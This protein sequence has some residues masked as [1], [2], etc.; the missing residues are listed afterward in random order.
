MKRL[1]VVLTCAMAC[2]D[3]TV[4]DSGGRSLGVP[5]PSS[6]VAATPKGPEKDIFV[7]PKRTKRNAS[8][9]DVRSNARGTFL[10][11]AAGLAIYAFS[12]DAQGQT[13]CGTNCTSV[14]PPVTVDKLPAVKSAAIDTMK[15]G[16]TLRPDGSRQLTYNGLPLYYSESDVK[17]E[18]TWGHYAMSFGGHFALIGPDGKPLPAPR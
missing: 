4:P 6:G 13:G 8:A 1:V 11:D 2:G 12:E 7:F 14:W 16:T 17:P 9:L 18:D 3:R 5:V 10:V 15:L